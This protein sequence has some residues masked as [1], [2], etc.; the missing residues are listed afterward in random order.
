MLSTLLERPLTPVAGGQDL[1]LPSAS[2]RF[3]ALESNTCHVV[4][5]ESSVAKEYQAGSANLA[6]DIA[7]SGP[8]VCVHHTDF[9]LG[10]LGWIWKEALVV[11]ALKYQSAE[12]CHTGVA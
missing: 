7:G 2:R 3:E 9:S 5:H 10:R 12:E 1:P 11:D 4:S 6:V 8:G